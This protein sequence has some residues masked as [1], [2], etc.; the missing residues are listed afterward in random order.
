MNC[1]AQG[2]TASQRLHHKAGALRRQTT[3]ALSLLLARQPVDA[4]YLTDVLTE[5]LNVGVESVSPLKV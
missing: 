3:S 4:Q 1:L 2:H 5:G